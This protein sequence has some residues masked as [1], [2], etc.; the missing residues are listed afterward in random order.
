V[1]IALVLG[2][3]AAAGGIVLIAL[4]LRLRSL[5]LSLVHQSSGA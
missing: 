5:A 3:Y 2:I 4:G 1:G